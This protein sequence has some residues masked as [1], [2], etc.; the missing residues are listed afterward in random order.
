MGLLST[1]GRDP[2]YAETA[3]LT[4]DAE[5]CWVGGLFP[6]NRN[7]LHDKLVKGKSLAT[8]GSSIWLLAKGT[9]RKSSRRCRPSDIA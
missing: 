7:Q 6:E 8:P 4:V 2:D 1:L 9:L 5:N 3:E